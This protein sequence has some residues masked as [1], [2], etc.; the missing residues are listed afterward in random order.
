MEGRATGELEVGVLMAAWLTVPFGDS[1][2]SGGYGV[3]SR[4][5][6]R[7]LW[8][9]LRSHRKAQ[10]RAI[11]ATPPTVPPTAAPTR[12]VARAGSGDTDCVGEVGGSC[13]NVVTGE[14]CPVVRESSIVIAD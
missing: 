7:I 4:C 1:S 13:V 12:G 9:R 5:D 10:T 14:D 8:R 3:A 11:R 6:S 2:F